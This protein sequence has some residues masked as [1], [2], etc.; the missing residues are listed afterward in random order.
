M[1]SYFIFARIYIRHVYHDLLSL[2]HFIVKLIL[3]YKL[4]MFEFL[5]IFQFKTENRKN[6]FK[7]TIKFGGANL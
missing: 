5:K 2:C 3:D 1:V 6:L 7:E 4:K